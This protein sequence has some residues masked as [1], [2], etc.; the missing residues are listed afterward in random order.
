[1]MKYEHDL[2]N[3]GVTYIAGIDEAGRG[4]LAGPVVAAA[5]VFPKTISIQGVKDSKQL[6]H[7]RREVLFGEIQEK[8]V[9][10]GVGI[11]N[12]AEIDQ[13]NILQAALK[14]MNH[15]VDNLSVSPEHLLIDGN[16]LPDCLISKSAIIQGDQ[17]C[18]S[19]AAASIVA[20]VTRDR[21]LIKFHE[22]FPEYGFAKHKGYGT[23]A[24][25]DAIRSYGY[26][27][28]HRRSFQVKGL[29]R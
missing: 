24:H 23:K 29:H 15:A 10:V 5:V 11:I 12:A 7:K 4:P 6:S 19:I 18:F 21:M 13:I 20:K 17:K 16:Q 9:A 22:Q 25:I 8:A 2:W 28:I 27:P 14:A 26:C 1:M 3:R